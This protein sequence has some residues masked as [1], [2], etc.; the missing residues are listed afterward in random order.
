M[1]AIGIEV[2][3]RTRLL[4][5]VVGLLEAGACREGSPALRDRDQVSGRFGVGDRLEPVTVEGERGDAAQRALPAPRVVEEPAPLGAQPA[6]PDRQLVR[7][8]QCLVALGL[9]TC[10]LDRGP[11]PVGD[12]G[13]RLAPR[14]PERVDQVPP[15]R[16]PPDQALAHGEPLALEHVGRL[17]DPLVEDRRHAAHPCERSGGLLGPLQWRRHDVGDVPVADPLGDALGHGLPAVGEHEPRRAPVEDPLG[18]VDLA[19]AQQVYDGHLV[20]PAAWAAAGNASSTCCTAMSS[21]AEEQN[22]ASNALGGR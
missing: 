16:G 20:P 2:G 22:H 6:D 21:W 19:V 11:H 4:A 17:D 8:D 5:Q 3:V 18:V 1:S 12:L 10:V 7:H 9:T 15:D 13:V 14:R